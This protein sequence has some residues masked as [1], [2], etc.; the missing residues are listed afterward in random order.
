V[1]YPTAGSVFHSQPAIRATHFDGNTSTDLVYMQHE[2]QELGSG[3]VLTTIRLKDSYY[4]FFVELCIRSY[5]ADDVFE[6]WAQVYHQEPAAVTLYEVASAGLVV[7]ATSYWLRHYRRD[8]GDRLIASDTQLTPLLE[9]VKSMDGFV[10]PQVT[11]P[12][13]VV[14]LAGA[15]SSE[16]AALGGAL[17][18]AGDFVDSFEYEEPGS[19]FPYKRA[20]VITR[21][22]ILGSTNPRLI[23][24]TFLPDRNFVTSP[25]VFT[26]HERGVQAAV[27]RLRAW[28]R[29]Q[30]SK[31]RAAVRSLLDLPEG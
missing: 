29:A 22:R 6:E 30:Y 15:Q 11:E 10:G 17:L 2:T 9:F 5:A 23:P 21:L 31:G 12:V 1:V 28:A 3:V 26:Y 27:A 25:M 4:P 13:F 24:S 19:I 8:Q 18:T 16:G 14:S 7:N 20:P